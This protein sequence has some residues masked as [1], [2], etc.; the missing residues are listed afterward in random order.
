V[1]PSNLTVSLYGNYWLTCL[2]SSF[3]AHLERFV[4]F[5]R[6]KYYF[7]GFISVLYISYRKSK[8]SIFISRIFEGKTSYYHQMPF[9]SNFSVKFTFCRIMHGPFCHTRF[10]RETSRNPIGGN[11]TNRIYPRSSNH[12]ILQ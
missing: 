12:E 2:K 11:S 4:V 8:I 9:R 3:L 7:S 1:V 10:W 6:S 5:L